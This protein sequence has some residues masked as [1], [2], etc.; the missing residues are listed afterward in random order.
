MT[1]RT[2]TLVPILDAAHGVE[3]P[4][5][6]SPD[7]SHKEYEWSRVI[8]SILA[9][10]LTHHGFRVEFTNTAE[11]EIGL[12]K[13]KN[14]ANSI[15]C[16]TGQIK[17]L[18]SLHNNAAG[19]DNNWHSA[20]GIEI[21]TSKGQTLSDKFAEVIFDNFKQDFP[22]LEGFKYRVDTTDNDNDK[23]SNFTVLMGSSYSAVLIEWLFQDNLKDLGLL[24]CPLINDRL[25]KSLVKSLIYIDEHINEFI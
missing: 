17:F 9:D 4:G 24:K 20:R 19:C 2:R 16:S 6:C 15:K 25:V 7:K 8:L 12:S 3:V 21:Y 1:K 11:N 5:K 22:T 10:E 18:L 14:I 23:E 13:R